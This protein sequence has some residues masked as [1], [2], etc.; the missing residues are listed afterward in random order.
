MNFKELSN[1]IRIV[2]LGSLSRAAVSLNMAQ[3]ALGLQIRNLEHEFNKQLLVRHSRGVYPTEAGKILLI[4]ARTI[5]QEIENSKQKIAEVDTHASN[6]RIGMTSSANGLLLTELYRRCQNQHP[7]IRLDIVEGNSGR[8]ARMLQI[9]EI[10]LGCLYSDGGVADL[11]HKTVLKDEWVFISPP[12]NAPSTKVVSFASLEG[13]PLV[14]PS[15]SSGLRLRVEHEARARG[16]ELNI[17]LEVQSGSL[18]QRLIEQGVGHTILPRMEAREAIADGRLHAA[19]IIEPEFP[20][21]TLISHRKTPV[22]S[23][24]ALAVKDLLMEIAQS[25]SHDL[26]MM[27]G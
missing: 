21:V 26:Q 22:L 6:V 24:S 13:L 7:D 14:L 12:A 11:V 1:F 25:M 27:Q 4:H 19:R 8:L 2:E 16:I 17:I 3:P 9:G 23:P 5:L 18:K 10:E 15:R 20:S